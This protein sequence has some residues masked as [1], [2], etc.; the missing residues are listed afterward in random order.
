MTLISLPAICSPHFLFHQC[1]S[2]VIKRWKMDGCAGMRGAGKNQ[3]LLSSAAF[4]EA[5]VRL[6]SFYILI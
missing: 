3:T 4:D 5:R 6:S 2:A 1:N